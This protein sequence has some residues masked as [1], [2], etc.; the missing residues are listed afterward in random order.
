MLTFEEFQ[1]EFSEIW[2]QIGSQYEYGDDSREALCKV[3][4]RDLQ[5][6]ETP[7][8]GIIERYVEEFGERPEGTVHELDVTEEHGRLHNLVR[9][10]IMG[11]TIAG[12]SDDQIGMAMF[13]IGRRWGMRE[14]ANAM[15]S[16]DPSSFAAE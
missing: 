15:G 6:G 1:A 11:G 5:L 3:M 2:K 10:F 16:I 14:A 13:V 9:Q 12:L 4:H 8:D 7:D